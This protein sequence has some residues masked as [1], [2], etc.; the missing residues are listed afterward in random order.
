M[1]VVGF[2]LA[3]FEF[4]QRRMTLDFFNDARSQPLGCNFVVLMQEVVLQQENLL[5]DFEN[6]ELS[7][8]VMSFFLSCLGFGCILTSRFF[9]VLSKRSI[10]LRGT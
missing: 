6:R 7:F 10:F 8:L 5:P 1:Q 9:G 3:S 2:S 4:N